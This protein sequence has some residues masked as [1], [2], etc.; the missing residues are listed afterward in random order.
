MIYEANNNISL[1]NKN[2]QLNE[3]KRINFNNGYYIGEIK[4]GKL[5]D[6]G[7]RFFN[8]GKRHDAYYINGIKEGEGMSTFP[9][10]EGLFIGEYKCDQVNGLGS[11]YFSNKAKYSGE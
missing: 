8:D 5:H 2:I 3:K 10:D 9:A 4:E 6:F 7:S 1:I 11:K